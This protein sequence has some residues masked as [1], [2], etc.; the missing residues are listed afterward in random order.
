M[1]DKLSRRGVKATG[2]NP[3]APGVRRQEIAQALAGLNAADDASGDERSA[4]ELARSLDESFPGATPNIA[5]LLTGF[6]R[7]AEHPE[8]E[9]QDLW[10]L[11]RE[12]G[13]YPLLTPARSMGAPD[14]DKL[15][16]DGSGLPF[17]QW[18]L[19][20]HNLRLVVWL[21]RQWRGRGVEL[22]DLVQEGTIGLMTAAGRFD[23][24]RGYRFT[25]YAY[26]WVLQGI[27]H[28][29]LTSTMFFAGQCTR[30]QNC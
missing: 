8:A 4:L 23:P 7:V 26:W 15:A 27:T 11:V 22:P 21:A 10:P 25:T 29:L 13:Q 16:P 20:V 14:G 19:I 12:A 24:R 17:H 28:A 5:D 6:E 1:V 30:L 18:R 2:A 3:A 9:T